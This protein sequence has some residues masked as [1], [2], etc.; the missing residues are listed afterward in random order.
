MSETC[1]HVAALLFRVEA[2]VTSRLTNPACTSRPCEWLPRRQ[3]VRPMKIS[4]M[5]ISRETLRKN[6]KLKK[7][8]L[9]PTPKKSY[10]PLEQC[11]IKPFSL[12]AVGDALA[13][14]LALA[15]RNPG[16]VYMVVCLL[17]F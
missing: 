8:K 13:L 6:K 11:S 1:N 16:L 5:D 10:N 4:D 14:A 12:R 9:V 3:D 17:F 7:R 15:D 2:A